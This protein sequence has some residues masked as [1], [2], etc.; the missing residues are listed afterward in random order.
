MNERDDDSV[1][2]EAETAA[3]EVVDLAAKQFGE[4]EDLVRHRESPAPINDDP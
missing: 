3:L 2:D 1:F 4:K